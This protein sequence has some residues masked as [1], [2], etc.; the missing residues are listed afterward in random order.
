MALGKII[1]SDKHRAL[2][3]NLE[4]VNIVTYS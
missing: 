3:D 1:L 4:G 2:T